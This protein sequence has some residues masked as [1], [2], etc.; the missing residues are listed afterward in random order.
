PDIS[1]PVL[2][3]RAA[4]MFLDMLQAYGDLALRKGHSSLAWG[5]CFPSETA[6]RSAQSR[7]NKAGVV[8]YRETGSNRPVLMVTDRYTPKDIFHPERFWKKKWH[9]TWSILMYDIPEEDRVFRNSLRRFLRRLRMGCLQKS[10]WVSPWDIRPSYDDLVQ[11]VGIEFV[12][13][14]F[15]AR[16][17]LYRDPGEIVRA[18]WD[19]V[20]L[21]E[22]QQEYVRYVKS[23][24]NAVSSGIVADEELEE[25]ARNEMEAFA[26]A[27]TDDPL[28][29][30]ELHPHGYI[31]PDVHKAHLAF[32][33][34]MRIRLKGIR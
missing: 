23:T 28:L 18:A 22:T 29:P 14:L 11:T 9:G 20:S 30:K 34:T 16:S 15:E 25:Y 32:V 1:F 19:F 10:V 33:E 12:A 3:R 5:T 26:T 31:G 13:H 2:R 27:M 6:C 4:D 7:L 8:A 24:E 17:V 21:S